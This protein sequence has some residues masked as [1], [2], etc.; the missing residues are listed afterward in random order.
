MRQRYYNP[1]IKRFINQ[2]ILT[3]DLSNSQSL[4]QYCYVQGNPVSYTDPFGLSPLNGLF[5]NTNFAHG[6][7]GLL[8]CI[9]GPVGSLASLADGL[10]YAFVD[11][12]YGMAALCFMDVVA[13]GMCRTATSLLKANK[14]QNTAQVLLNSSRIM[15]NAASFGMCA[16]ATMATGFAMYDKYHIQGQAF[17]SD[18]KWEILGLGMSILGGVISGRGIA[19]NTK[20]LGT[21]LQHEGFTNTMKGEVLEFANGMFKKTSEVV[22][23][24]GSGLRMNLQFFGGGSSKTSYG[25]SSIKNKT[26]PKP[27]GTGPH[28]LKIEEIASQITDGKIIAGGGRGY[29]PEAVIQTPGGVKSSR[30]PDILIQR[31]DG[32][33]YGINVGKTTAK[34][35]PIKGAVEAIYDLEDVGIPMY[36]VGY[37]K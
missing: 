13:F 15:S 18:T 14:L 37:D 1:E 33:M 21:M 30:R 6:F 26:G 22:Q 20:K 35:A 9:P 8:S 2:D 32:S 28:N 27:K 3:G 17:D 16:N 12:D 29:P 24:S 4:N 34:G 36:F 31:P 25:K 19:K 10:V 5:S 23:S 11:K 7:F